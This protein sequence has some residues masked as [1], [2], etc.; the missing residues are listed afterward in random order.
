MSYTTPRNECLGAS[1]SSSEDVEELLTLLLSQALSRPSTAEFSVL[2][3]DGS[4]SGGACPLTLS[5][6]EGREEESAARSLSILASFQLVLACNHP[7]R[8]TGAVSSV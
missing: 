5:S 2:A 6:R 3:F 7:D 8:F 1:D 4:L